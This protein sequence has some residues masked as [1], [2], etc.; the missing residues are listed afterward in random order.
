MP[1]HLANELLLTIFRCLDDVYDARALSHAN[2]PFRKL[3]LFIPELWTTLDSRLGPSAAGVFARR[4]IDQRLQVILYHRNLEDREF[5]TCRMFLDVALQYA[6]RWTRFTV[7][8]WLLQVVEFAT[9]HCATHFLGSPDGGNQ[10]RL[11][12]EV[13][14]RANAQWKGR[15]EGYTELRCLPF[16]ARSLILDSVHSFEPQW[17]PQLEILELLHLELTVADVVYLVQAA[18]LLRR[19]LVGEFASPEPDTRAPAFPSIILDHLQALELRRTSDS[20]IPEW[21]RHV[22]MINLRQLNLTIAATAPDDLAFALSM[23]DHNY[24]IEL[25][26]IKF[27]RHTP[28]PTDLLTRRRRKKVNPN[29]A[30]PFGRLLA[31]PRLVALRLEGT[32][33]KDVDITLLVELPQLESL[34]LLFEDLLSPIGLQHLVDARL[35]D[36]AVCALREL[37]VMWCQLLPTTVAGNFSARVPHVKWMSGDEEQDGQSDADEYIA[38]TDDQE[39]ETDNEDDVSDDVSLIALRQEA[40][41]V[42]RGFRVMQHLPI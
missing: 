23:I 36:P 42:G 18:P 39:S 41:L 5:D 24:P 7:D 6:D 38:D 20:Q 10:L 19:L 4:S 9:E 32:Q 3:A 26:T 17:F 1:P 34:A 33:L 37:T 28:K 14:L 22:R 12:E 21:F 30:P 16:T 8:A 13:V 15:K 11:L 31:F 27:M 2:R 40:R 35:H 25:L 29:P